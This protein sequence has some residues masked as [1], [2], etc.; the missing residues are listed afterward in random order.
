VFYFVGYVPFTEE[1]LNFFY[2]VKKIMQYSNVDKRILSY[3]LVL[4]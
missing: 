4:N 2:N 3:L 1:E